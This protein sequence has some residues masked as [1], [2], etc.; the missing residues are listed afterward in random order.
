MINLFGSSLPFC[1]FDCLVCCSSTVAMIINLLMGADARGTR[2]QQ[3]RDG[4]AAH[5]TR[6][7]LL[8]SLSFSLGRRPVYCIAPKALF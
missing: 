7:G 5:S 3:R 1:L 4:F 8:V 2:G 6:V